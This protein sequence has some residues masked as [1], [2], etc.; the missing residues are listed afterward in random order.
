MSVL[1][2]NCPECKT[3][4]ITMRMTGYSVP[5]QSGNRSGRRPFGYVFG[6]CSQCEKPS[7]YTFDSNGQA[8]WEG[9]IQ[10]I[11][12]EMN[13]TALNDISASN[14]PIQPF[15]SSQLKSEAPDHLPEDV[16]KAFQQGE[17]NFDMPGHEEASATMYR[18]ALERA[19][20]S[21][22]PSLGGSLAAKI[23]GL[24]DNGTLPQ[25][26]GDWATE[27][28]IIGNDGAHD[29]EVSRDDLKAARMFCDSFLR[30]LITLPKEV[31]LRRLNP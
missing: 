31:E 4:K 13:K 18:R 7:A 30:Y 22:H 5:A 29:D 6:I 28:R 16:L 20:K 15:T 14:Y 10:Y 25:A 8:T 24:V 26:L 3:K 19:L 1:V 21:T 9:V 12:G 27:I 23:R 2:A 17:T 11:A